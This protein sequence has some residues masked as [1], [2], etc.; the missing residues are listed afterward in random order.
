M[1]RFKYINSFTEEEDHLYDNYRN[2]GY[3]YEHHILKNVISSELFANPVNDT[4]LR[5][6]EK[7]IE[8]LINAVKQIKL[9]YAYT[10]DKYAK[11]IN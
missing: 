10:Y 8:E 9:A 2:L 6:I 7:L 3:D 4:P 5:Q 11:N 1:P